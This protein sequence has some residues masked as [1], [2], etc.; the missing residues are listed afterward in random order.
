M[1][2][3]KSSV[4]ITGGSRGLG[5]ALGRL[6]AREGARVALVARDLDAT[7]QVADEIRAAGGEAHALAA[8]LG[9]KEAIHPL[10]AQAAA[11]LGSIDLLIHGASTLGPSPLSL[12]LDTD[13]EDV[14]R[15]LAVNVLGPFRLSKVVAGAMALRGRGVLVHI[16]SDAAV[17]SYPTWGAYGLSKAALDHLSRTWDAELSPLGVRSLSVD[18]GE[19]DT[20][21]H[22]EAMPDADRSGLARPEEVAARIIRMLRRAELLPPGARLRASEEV[23]P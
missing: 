14:E 23:A 22:A 15:A 6:L 8:D 5:A 2:I 7:R 21:M 4:L 12:L 3:E 17:E 20:R 18:P 10:A 13:C 1:N 19:M 9:D 11:L 16:S